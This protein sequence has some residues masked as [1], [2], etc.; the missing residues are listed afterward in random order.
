MDI[1]D[2]M[3][4]AAADL[5]R[6]RDAKLSLTE[7]LKVMFR[8]YRA[9]LDELD[10]SNQIGKSVKASRKDVD[11]AC[12][13]ITKA[14]GAYLDGFPHKAYRSL[15]TALARLEPHLEG[16]RAPLQS[17]GPLYRVRQVKTLE[18]LERKDIF[19]VPF[20]KR[21]MVASARYSIS[22]WPSLYLGGSLWVCWE[23]LGRPPFHTLA[24]SSFCASRRLS[25]LDFGYRPQI[26][27]DLFR[28]RNPDDPTFFTD[29][30]MAAFIV[31][32]PLLATCSL[33]P[34]EPGATFVPE[35]IVPQLLLQWLRNE[36]EEID[37]LRYFSTRIGQHLTI[38]AAA[39]NYVFPVQKQGNDGLCSSLTRT[40]ALNCPIS[41]SVLESITPR[42]MSPLRT[43]REFWPTKDFQM[44]YD[45]TAFASL[46][47][48]LNSL[49][50]DVIPV[51]R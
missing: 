9:L 2:L 15:K 30:W 22:G 19:H 14:I 45:D 16:L 38:P 5:P 21:H 37:G 51:V 4:S 46:E 1:R 29:E 26:A 32:W 28:P 41:W 8:K 25:V 20:E 12:R 31:C 40:F 36:A 17:I 44:K 33:R 42:A 6:G 7:Q 13:Q 50:H 24:L 18:E 48:K 23:E 27:I 11:S 43:E 3:N 34:L 10:T 49:P 35:Y 39:I 47:H